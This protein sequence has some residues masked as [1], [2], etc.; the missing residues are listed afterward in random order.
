MRLINASDWLKKELGDWIFYSP[1]DEL[2]EKIV[3]I[4]DE[5]FW[6]DYPLEFACVMENLKSHQIYAI[7]DHFGCEPLFYHQDKSTFLF[8]SSL[9]DIISHLKQPPSL[10]EKIIYQSLINC[11]TV[12]DVYTDDTLYQGIYRIEPASITSFDNDKIKKR[13]FWQLS[14]NPKPILYKNKE[15]YIEHFSEV[16]HRGIQIQTNGQKSIA[17]EFSGGLDSS[18]VVTGLNQLNKNA[19][20]YFHAAPKD[21]KTADDKS[22]AKALVDAYG[23]KDV[24]YDYAKDF[25]LAEIC[26]I[27]ANY[28]AGLPQYFF[29]IGASNI[30]QRVQENHHPILLSGF[31]GDE[32][33]STHAPLS[34]VMRAY[35]QG[36]HWLKAWQECVFDNQVQ[37]KNLSSA[38]LMSQLIKNTHPKTIQTLSR[39]KSFRKKKQPNFSSVRP[40]RNDLWAHEYDL[41]QGI[42]AHHLRGR[43]EE[44]AIM[45]KHYGFTYRYP[46]LFPKLVEFCHAIPIAYKRQNGI[47]RYMIRQYLAKHAP[48][49]VFEKHQKIGA[50]MPAT[51]YQMKSA[52]DKGSYQG[53]FDNLPYLEKANEIRKAH[54]HNPNAKLLHRTLLYTLKLGMNKA[55]KI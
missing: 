47:N 40:L 22:Y 36:G 28:F 9:A 31:G 27:A 20:L 21:A 42:C 4:P 55:A 23:L 17:S 18:T 14:K 32:C 33:A 30:H 29:P 50:I 52:F 44:S 51:L 5:I 43:I 38:Q 39:L 25:N 8:A 41:M 2:L 45:A 6:R 26:Q 16:L 12:N 10:N 46:L 34:I 19:H 11:C 7:R 37:Q 3:E 48:K 1:N 13:Y 49:K 53:L 35:W 15:E 24:C 54:P